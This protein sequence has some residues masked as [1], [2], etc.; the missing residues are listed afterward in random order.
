VKTLV[1]VLAKSRGVSSRPKCVAVLDAHD[2]LAEDTSGRVRIEVLGTQRLQAP[3]ADLH[4]HSRI[5]PRFFSSFGQ[6]QKRRRRY[7]RGSEARGNSTEFDRGTP[8]DFARGGVLPE[9]TVTMGAG[10]EVTAVLFLFGTESGHATFVKLNCDANSFTLLEGW[11]T[12]VPFCAVPSL[13]GRISSRW[14]IT[15]AI[16]LCVWAETGL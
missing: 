11:Y 9:S 12:I 6:V 14:G 2:C 16:E 3:I 5:A 8:A 1:L 13:R 15:G 10:K 4:T 7:R